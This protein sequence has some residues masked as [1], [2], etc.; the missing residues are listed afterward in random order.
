MVIFSSS[1]A[2]LKILIER[3]MTYHQQSLTPKISPTEP[4]FN[5]KYLLVLKY[6]SL[7]LTFLSVGTFFTIKHRPHLMVNLFMTQELLIFSAPV[8]NPIRIKN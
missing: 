4:Y 1:C 2:N 8:R 7:D 3:G 6:A 5:M